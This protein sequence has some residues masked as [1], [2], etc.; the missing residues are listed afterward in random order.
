[1]AI[2]YTN[3]F[4]N[5]LK[6]IISAVNLMDDWYSDLETIRSDINTKFVAAG[7][8]NLLGIMQTSVN[9]SLDQGFS[10]ITLMASR[11]N[12]VLVDRTTVLNELPR[13]LSS[14]IQSVV[15]ELIKDMNENSESVAASTVTIGS[16]TKT[17]T[18][19]NTGTIIL[20][21]KLSGIDAPAY[22]SRVNREYANIDSQ[23]SL[24]SDSLRVCC[25]ADSE[26][27]RTSSGS[28]RFV[29]TGKPQ[30]PSLL[31][32]L[33]KGSGGSTFITTAQASSVVNLGFDSFASNV[34]SGWTV[35]SGTAGTDFLAETTEIVYTGSSL[36]I[37]GNCELSLP[38]ESF[39]QPL[40]HYNCG[41]LV[42]SDGLVTGAVLNVFLE[43]T[44][45]TTEGTG[46]EID[47]NAAALNAQTAFDVENFA[48][49]LPA[50]TPSNLT[51]RIEVT[52][53]SAG[54]IYLDF[55]WL[56]RPAYH[57]GIA[58][59]VISGRE[60]FLRDDQFAFDVTNNDSG[61]YQ[62][63]FRDQ[64]GVQLPTSGSPTIAF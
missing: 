35:V 15:D 5:R 41:F 29:I 28:E 19:T 47:M 31:H 24:T 45:Y 49:V 4:T 38:I 20:S 37:A 54:K 16:V 40:G 18:N 61:T 23:L 42:K 25:T 62:K 12:D 30:A 51:L 10:A 43:G 63:F 1:M 48:V 9:T 64:F 6:A 33:S 39:V 17:T 11:A 56:S 55:G 57:N 32:Y 50:T 8:Q 2:N 3:L 26:V 7:S 21:K 22:Y 52:G 14:D 13:L 58:I 59:Q 53:M 34:P 36:E 27:D 44:G 60:V 46:N